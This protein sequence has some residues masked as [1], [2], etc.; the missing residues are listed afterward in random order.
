MAAMEV[1]EETVTNFMALTDANE[2]VAR[3]FL[4][5][6]NGDLAQAAELFFES[7]EMVTTFNQASA[8][9]AHDP[10]RLPEARPATQ[11]T[12]GVHARPSD[13]ARDGHTPIQIESDSEFEDDI[14]DNESAAVQAETVARSAQEEEDAAMAKRLQEELY[15]EP[16]TTTAADGI[17]APMGRTTETLVAS[18]FDMG[19]GEHDEVAMQV[20]DQLNRRRQQLHNPR[21]LRTTS[22]AC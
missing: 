18:G 8:S 19:E 16:T 6:T 5:V 2:H 1:D 10:P 17:R 22:P 21:E 3:S 14:F 7:P 15:A 11:P 12:Y 9:R 13:D 4:E 20:M